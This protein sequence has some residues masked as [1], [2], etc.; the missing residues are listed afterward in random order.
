MAGRVNWTVTQHRGIAWDDLESL[1]QR[2]ASEIAASPRAAR[3]LLSEPS[4][5][6]TRG[7]SGTPEGLLVPSDRL[8][9]DGIAVRDARRGGQWT[10]H[11]PGQLLVYPSIK[12]AQWG[13]GSRG[14]R[15]FVDDFRSALADSLASLGAMTKPGD[16]PYGLYAG[17]GKVASFGLAVEHGVTTHGAAIYIEPQSGF[18]AIHPCGVP[19]QRIVSLRELGCGT[20]WPD[21]AQA[22][23]M[24][25]KKHFAIEQKLLL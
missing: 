9:R 16:N 3:L 8:A 20:D 14:V 5:T 7:R 4:A 17:D 21:V 11:G 2:H 18:S 13:Y 12:L 1:R 15:R 24:A 22:V 25:M 10:F 23:E 19:D 6:L